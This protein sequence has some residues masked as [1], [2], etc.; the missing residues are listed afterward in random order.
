L[1]YSHQPE[2]KL[3]F[4]AGYV[5]TNCFCFVVR[6]A[7]G[8]G[9]EHPRKKTLTTENAKGTKRETD[10]CPQKGRRNDA[11]AGSGEGGER[12]MAKNK[13]IEHSTLNIERP[14]KRG[15][16]TKSTKRGID[17][18]PQKGRRNNAETGR[19]KYA[20]V[21][22]ACGR[23]ARN[24]KRKT[25]NTEH[26]TSNVEG[27]W[28][29]GGFRR[30][31][32]LYGRG[33][34]LKLGGMLSLESCPIFSQLQA[35]ELKVLQ[36]AAQLRAFKP[37]EDIFKEGDTGDG[38]YVVKRGMVQITGLITLHDRHAFSKVGP[39]ELFGEMAVLEN[40]PRSASATALEEVEVYFIPRE[41]MLELVERSPQLAMGLLREISNRLREFNRQYVNEVLQ[42][43]RLALVGRFA[44]TIVHDLKNPLNIIGLSAELAVMEKATME[45]R[46]LA[47]QRISKQVERISELVNEILEFTQG[48][49]VAFV[50][51][52]ADYDVFVQALLDEIRPEIEVKSVTIE[53]ENQPPT[54]RLLLNPKRMRRV[55]YNLIH[56][57]TEAMPTGGKITMRFIVT[58]KEVVTE[59]EDSGPGIAPE[60]ADRL[61]HAFATYGKEHGT[62]LGLSI[63]KKIVEDHRGRIFARN[64]PGRGAVFSFALP[65]PEGEQKAAASGS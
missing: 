30:C 13:N 53:L 16:T 59:I 64:E 43:E 41:A 60:I 3:S 52:Q 47:K 19:G 18:C 11:E 20:V 9:G 2:P 27:R 32:L 51:A 39:G 57:A 38:V 36:G 1:S 65:V 21:R 8:R 22:V 7:W 15:E 33:V 46:R 23:G 58:E 55:F 48:S 24:G 35:G 54:V 12:G 14:N 5:K 34:W 44:R 10:L 26:G 6:V 42:R 28:D 45:G 31:C 49:H 63:S 29:G 25:S 4:A 62:G 40:K 17:F 50:L 37:N 56:N 61:F